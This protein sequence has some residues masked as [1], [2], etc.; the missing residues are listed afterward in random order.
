MLDIAR[1]RGLKV[2]GHLCAVGFREAAQA[3][4]NNLEHGLAVDTEFFSKKKVDECP[5]RNEWLPE[6]AK[7]DVMSEPVQSMIRELVNRRVAI[8]S[9]LAIFE[10]FVSERFQ[11]DPRMRDVRG[12]V[13]VK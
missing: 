11:L 9:T 10:A 6:L 8:T 13:G 3:G 12:L 5:N 1:K 2:T 7:I 4:I